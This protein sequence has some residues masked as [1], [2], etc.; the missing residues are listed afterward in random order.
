MNPRTLTWDDVPRLHELLARRWAVDDP[1]AQMHVGDFYWALRTTPNADPLADTRVWPRTDGS[2]A[3]FARLDPP[4][5]GDA[6]VDP[7]ADSSMLDEALAWLE[8]SYR[9]RGSGAITVVVVD[10]DTRRVEALGRR[11]YTPGDGG[12]TRLWQRLDSETG[13]SPLPPG[14]LLGH[15]ETTD[16]MRR[17]AFVETSSF[18]YEG[19]T[20]ESWRLLTQRLPHYRPELDLIAA[21]PDGTGASA[22]TVWYDETTLCGEFEAVGT[23]KPYQRR[24]LGRAVILEGLRRLRRLGAAQAVVQTQITN[25]A[26]IALYQSCG[27][28][29]VGEDRAWTRSLRA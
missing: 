17:R 29:V 19:V 12:N 21:T 10:G 25:T 27:F 1:R 11:G 2:L 9:E 20:A 13:A 16:D 28:E 23:S 8:D 15:V 6:V 18:D 24:G 26:A 7:A 5:L 3:A 14:F 4:D 22:C